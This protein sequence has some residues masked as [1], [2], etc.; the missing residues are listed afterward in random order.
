MDRHRYSFVAIAAIA[1]S[2]VTA[3]GCAA[4]GRYSPT[5]GLENRGIY[6]PAKYPRGEW[7]QTS[8]L[9]QDA[10]FT[11]ADGT[12]LH[13][14]YVNCAQPK[15]HALLLHG[16]AG[17]VTLLAETLRTLNR[18]HNLSVLALDYRG[19]GKSEGKPSEEGLYQDAR[20]AR[21]WLA[22]KEGIAETDVIL[23]G[24]SLGG[25]V[26]VDLAARD[27]ARGLVLSNTFTSLPAAAQHQVPWLP[28]N[29][30]LSTQMDSLAKIKEYRGP[31]LISHSEADEVVPFT[32]GQALYDAAPGPKRLINNHGS[33]HNDPQSE[34]YR[35]A[36]DEFLTQ[37]PP[38]G[39]SRVKTASL[40][41]Q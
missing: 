23:M 28:M 29:L 1:V 16:N 27:G 5:A 8:V 33:K 17:N 25:A 32:Q 30:V 13:G 20:A 11:A 35:V 6:Q 38:L 22:E 9:A 15:G 21:R 19:F 31:L 26:A 2:A 41:V 36:L 24:V 34:E 39:S 18:R 12:K 7:N 40:N 37:L 3:P 14:W 4:L 10:N